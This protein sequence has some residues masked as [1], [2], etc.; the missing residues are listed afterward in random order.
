ML[1]NKNELNI[2]NNMAADADAKTYLLLDLEGCE[3]TLCDFFTENVLS[4]AHSL[5]EIDSNVVE[6]KN[7]RTEYKRVHRQLKPLIEDYD[8]S[9]KPAYDATCEKISAYVIDAKAEKKNRSDALQEQEMKDKKSAED[10]QLLQEQKKHKERTEQEDR[11][12]D[13]KN[14]EI[15]EKTTQIKA[16]CSSVQTLKDDEVLDLKSNL[17]NI[18]QELRELRDM[19]DKFEN[20]ISNFIKKE[21]IIKDLAAEY[22]KAS[23]AAAKYKDDLKTEIKKR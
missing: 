13:I 12:S 23:T 17:N 1:K 14:K 9:T 6:L 3:E 11:I 18:D 2:E 10:A 4:E 22:K 20:L 21:D 8:T 19:R 5:A 7:L 15:K 16:M